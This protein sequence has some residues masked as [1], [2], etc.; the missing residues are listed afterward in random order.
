[1]ASNIITFQYIV[2]H[3]FAILTI[4]DSLYHLISANDTKLENGLET[5]YATKIYITMGI[6]LIFT[7]IFIIGLIFIKTKSSFNI[8]SIGINFICSLVIL[9]VTTTFIPFHH[10]VLMIND[11]DDGGDGGDTYISKHNDGG[12]MVRFLRL[13]DQNMMAFSTLLSVVLAII[14]GI[15]IRSHDPN[16]SHR[17]MVYLGFIG[18]IF[19]RLLKMM[20]LP[21]IFASLVFAIGNI[22]A[23]LSGKIAFRAITYYF[24]TTIIA[25]I[26][27][28]ILVVLIQPGKRGTIDNV[29]DSG[30]SIKPITTMDTILDLIRNL[31]PG[32]LFEATFAYYSTILRCNETAVDC[33]QLPLDKWDIGSMMS[34]EASNILGIV[35]F[36]AIFGAMIPQVDDRDTMVR[37]FS[38]L[39]D[40]MMKLT[41][42][43]IRLTPIGVIF[44]ILPQIIKV[45]DLSVMFGAI[46]FYSLVVLV[47]IAFQGI[48]TLPIIYFIMTR[49]NPITLFKHLFPALVTGFGTSSSSATMPVTFKCLEDGA[50]LDK[51]IVRFCIPVGSTINMDGT[52]LYEAVAAIFIA[53]Y[54]DVELDWVKLII[55]TITATAASIGAAGIPQ[56]GLVTMIIVLNA[57]GLPAEDAA[58]IVVVDWML[59]RFRTILNILGDAFGC[60]IVNHL[61]QHDFDDMEQIS[62][63]IGCE[64]DM[65][66]TINTNIISIDESKNTETKF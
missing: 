5:N 63:K 48:I 41:S 42:A 44:L 52:A 9:I 24:S 1:M 13:I 12:G 66:Q 3:L 56:A 11:G 2:T 65:Q 59:D 37:F 46:G 64:N 45:K 54:R 14:I 55:I 7:I 26:T 57:V 29:A 50:K 27:G 10:V 40:I 18:E 61:S 58:L 20:I 62:S 15:I 39:N 6:R 32:N 19:L 23:Q 35:M 33:N 36:A 30:V 34:S 31:L 28:I 60:G 4:G 22:D 53:Q 49:K 51:R 21:L 8:V 38:A 16:W 25:I 17:Q 47:G 43:I